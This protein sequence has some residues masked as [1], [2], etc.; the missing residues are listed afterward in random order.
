MARHIADGDYATRYLEKIDASAAR[1]SALIKDILAYSKISNTEPQQE[2]VDL[3]AVLEH[4]KTDFELLI[5]EKQA[6]IV[7]TRLPEVKG[8]RFQFQQLFSNLHR[9]L[10]QV[11]RSGAACYYI[12]RGSERTGVAG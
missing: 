9:K 5:S 1:M 3:N 4:V 11:Y 8:N 2:N 7:S 6:R 10:A 12:Q